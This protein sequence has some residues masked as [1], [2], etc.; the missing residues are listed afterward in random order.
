MANYLTGSQRY[1]NRMDKLW[2]RC[3]RLEKE[4]LEKGGEPNPNLTDHATAARYGWTPAKIG[5]RSRFVKI[6]D[7]RA[8]AA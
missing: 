1:N 7:S 3:H 6:R 8:R 4:I 2:D 5:G